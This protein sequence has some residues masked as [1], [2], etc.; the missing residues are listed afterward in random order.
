MV[1][2]DE[3]MKKI[4]G[5]ISGKRL[6]LVQQAF[7][8]MDKTG[9]GVV[10]AHDLQGTY[11]PSKHPD[12]KAGKKRP[13]DVLEEFLS[14]FDVT[15]SDFEFDMLTATGSGWSSLGR[16]ICGVLLKYIGFH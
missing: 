1:D 7:R 14:T 4:R 16:G 5:T 10:N 15:V 9:D 6:A 13:E 2:C 8:V 11:D 3:F 12:V